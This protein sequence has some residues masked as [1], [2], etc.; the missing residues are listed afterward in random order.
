MAHEL[1]TIPN[2]IGTWVQVSQDQPLDG[3]MQDVLGTSKYIFRDYVNEQVVTGAQE[4]ARALHERIDNEH[5]PD[6]KEAAPG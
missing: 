6:Q 5:D 4:T 1:G 2:R 3:E